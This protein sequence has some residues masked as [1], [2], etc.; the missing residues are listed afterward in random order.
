MPIRGDITLIKASKA[1]RAGNISFNLVSGTIS[2]Y[3]A[4]ASD[5]V[6]VEV[7]EL[8]E[9]GELSPEE[10][11][12]PAPIIDM[13]YVKTGPVGEF[14]NVWKRAKEKSEGGAK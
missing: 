10:I 2:D 9:T 8:V 6:I 7:E 12:V 5:T 13:V 14:C 1:D 11:D 4:F 3:M